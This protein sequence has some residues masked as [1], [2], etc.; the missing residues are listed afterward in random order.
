MSC[1]NKETFIRQSVNKLVNE[2]KMKGNYLL[3]H[4]GVNIECGSKSY[5]FLDAFVGSFI[6]IV[7]KYSVQ[8]LN[9]SEYI[10]QYLVKVK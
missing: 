4:V 5:Y 1:A 6:T 8:L 2:F 3:K 10:R 9:T 7:Q